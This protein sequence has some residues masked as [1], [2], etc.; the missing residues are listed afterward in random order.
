MD[1]NCGSFGVLFENSPMGLFLSILEHFF[2]LYLG[3][4]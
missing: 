3:S 1:G 2:G 4:K